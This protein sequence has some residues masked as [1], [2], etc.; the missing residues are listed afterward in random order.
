MYYTIGSV[1]TVSV[2]GGGKREVKV[3]QKLP[4]IKNGQ[5]GFEGICQETGTN[6]W[7]YDKQIISRHF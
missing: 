6:V 2:F 5:P 1:L 4:D 7:G 3:T